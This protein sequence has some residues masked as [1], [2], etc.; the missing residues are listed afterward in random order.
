MCTSYEIHRNRY[1]YLIYTNNIAAPPSQIVT[2][3]IGTDVDRSTV[4]PAVVRASYEA[5]AAGVDGRC[6]D[7]ERIHY[8]PHRPLNVL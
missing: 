1:E 4:G 3:S 7:R 2:T 6:I 5:A 8:E